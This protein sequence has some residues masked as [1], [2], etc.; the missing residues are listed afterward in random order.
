MYYITLLV[1]AVISG[2]V[3]LAV[4]GNPAGAAVGGVVALFI[5]RLFWAAVSPDQ[6]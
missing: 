5:N 4:V 1:L 6:I 3:G 2:A